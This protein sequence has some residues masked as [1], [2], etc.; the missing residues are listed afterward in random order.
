MGKGSYLSDRASGF[1][2]AAYVTF[3]GQ[4]ART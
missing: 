3:Q 4:K 1:I 2:T